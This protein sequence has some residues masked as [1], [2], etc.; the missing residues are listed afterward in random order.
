MKSAHLS[1][2]FLFV[3]FVL[4]L[5]MRFFYFK[6]LIFNFKISLE[7]KSKPN[8]KKEGININISDIKNIQTKKQKNELMI[9]T[10]IQKHL[11]IQV[12]LLVILRV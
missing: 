11:V 1:P 10:L 3:V 5:F 6:Y 8:I 12:Q 2:S 4:Y 7:R 9:V